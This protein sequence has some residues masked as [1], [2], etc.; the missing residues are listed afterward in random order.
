[1]K[2]GWVVKELGDFCKISTGKSNTIDVSDG[3]EYA[4]F[5]R[6]KKIKRSSKYLF[7]CDAI[8]M[9]PPY[10]YKIL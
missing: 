6:S 7:D 5:D 10:L 8:F 4:F 9:R 1:M 3:G 2:E